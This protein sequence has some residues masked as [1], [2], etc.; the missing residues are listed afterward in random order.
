MLLLASG[1]GFVWRGLVCSADRPTNAKRALEPVVEATRRDWDASELRTEE[2]K[3]CREG[4]SR[5]SPWVRLPEREPS[6]ESIVGK[7]ARVVV[8]EA[9]IGS[10]WS[11]NGRTG[12]AH[13]K[14]DKNG[15]PR[16]SD[17]TR[18]WGSSAA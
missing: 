13:Q 14:R 10:W 4:I 6:R 2:A 3:N 5:L 9:P 18:A 1:N 11:E 12:G 16:R 7:T 15:L 17:Q 8:Q